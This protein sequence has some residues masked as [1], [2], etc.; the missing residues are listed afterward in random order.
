ML[1]APCVSLPA[2]F[3]LRAA[4][5]ARERIEI[6]YWSRGNFE[7]PAMNEMVR[8]LRIIGEVQG[9]IDWDRVIDRSFL[10]ADLHS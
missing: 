3:A 2:R 8:G 7:I 6:D 4:A 10:P 9:D 5:E 1:L